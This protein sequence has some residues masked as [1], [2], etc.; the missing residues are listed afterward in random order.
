MITDYRSVCLAAC[1]IAREAGEYIACERKRFTPADVELKGAR[2]LVSYVDKQTEQMV[3]ARLGE[4]LPD[5]GFVTE[6][7]TVSADGADRPLRWIVDPLDG[8]TNFVHDLSPY[9]VSLGLMDGDEIVAGVVYEVTRAEMFYAWRG[10]YAYLNGERIAVST[11]DRLDDALVGIGFSYGVLKCSDGFVDSIVGF[12]NTTHGIRRLG[13][14]AADL[15]YVACGRFDAFYHAGLS[16]WDVAAGA[17]IAQ[18]AGARVTD[19]AGGGDYVFGRQIIAA[20]PR[21]YDEFQPLVR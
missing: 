18:Q 17:L 3:V 14:A 1:D 11:V 8:T 16:P 6:E 2:N 15:V 21:I 9:C 7:G 20:T 5:A 13:S 19:Y 4:L 10:S 12:Q